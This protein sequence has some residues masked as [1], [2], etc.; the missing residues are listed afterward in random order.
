M[1]PTITPERLAAA[2]R[3]A[4]TARALTAQA[5]PTRA[6]PLALARWDAE[7]PKR[8]AARLAAEQAALVRATTPGRAW[9]DGA[10]RVPEQPKVTKAEPADDTPP[11]F[12][13]LVTPPT[14][15]TGG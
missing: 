9:V 10:E 14:A 2:L 15:A 8:E 5:T 13:D 7:A 11:T 4:P 3:G 1:L 6:L 12:V